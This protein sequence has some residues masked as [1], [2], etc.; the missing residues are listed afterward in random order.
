MPSLIA[1]E[2]VSVQPMSG[3]PV[4]DPCMILGTLTEHKEFPWKCLHCGSTELKRSLWG[5]IKPTQDL[6]AAR[7]RLIEKRTI[8]DFGNYIYRKFM[9]PDDGR[10]PNDRYRSWLEEKVGKQ[11]ED[12]DWDLLYG[13]DMDAWNKLRVTFKRHEDA[14][15]FE[16][17]CH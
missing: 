9:Y 4:C 3:S 15:L 13:T 7:T 11:G 16:L 8:M 6:I 17:A 14:I 2:L 10:E 5:F 1:T 12:W